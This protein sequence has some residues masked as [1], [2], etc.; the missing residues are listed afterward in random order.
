[1]TAPASGNEA[2]RRIR[3]EPYSRYM[4][5]MAQGILESKDRHWLLRRT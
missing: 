5:A 2:N 3:D 1:M 4:L